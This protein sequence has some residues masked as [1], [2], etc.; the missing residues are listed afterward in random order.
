MLARIMMMAGTPLA[1]YIANASGGASSMG[2]S[3]PASGVGGTVLDGDYM[4]V[5]YFSG[6]TIS[7]GSGAAFTTSTFTGTKV[8]SRRIE[9]SDLTTPF[10]FNVAGPYILYI[11]RGATSIGPAV[12]SGTLTGATEYPTE[13]AGFTPS[14]GAVAIMGFAI[15]QAPTST[16]AEVR[17]RIKGGV[18]FAGVFDVQDVELTTGWGYSTGLLVDLNGYSGGPFAIGTEDAVNTLTYRVHELF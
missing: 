11:V 13:I 15:G 9:P 18:P 5:E 2:F 16:Q 10:T 3:L 1:T 14:V 12:R 4:V 6:T 8:S 17:W 7:G